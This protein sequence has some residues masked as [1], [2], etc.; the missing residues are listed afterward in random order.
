MARMLPA[1]HTRTLA[2]RRRPLSPEQE[3]FYQVTG[4]PLDDQR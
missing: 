2:Y 1:F 3:R 4:A